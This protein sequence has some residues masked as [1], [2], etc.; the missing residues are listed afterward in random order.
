MST[1]YTVTAVDQ[2]GCVFSGDVFVE[3]IPVPTATFTAA[4]NAVY[5]DPIILTYTGTSI[6]I[7]VYNWN[8]AGATVLGGSNAGPYQVILGPIQELRL[9]P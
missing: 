7:A 1:L 4:P 5:P 6:Q 2:M 8:F 9:L 3:V